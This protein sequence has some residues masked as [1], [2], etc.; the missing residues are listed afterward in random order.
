MVKRL[1]VILL[2]LTCVL[3]LTTCDLVVALASLS[4]FPGYL[5]QAVASV[6]MQK[7]VEEFLGEDPENWGSEVYALRDA[8]GAE[9]IFLILH[10][11]SGG[12]WVYAFDTSLALISKAYLDYNNNVHLVGPGP[13]SSESFVVGNIAFDPATLLVD[14]QVETGAGE[15]ALYN[16]S[17]AM[18]MWSYFDGGT[19]ECFLDVRYNTGWPLYSGMNASTLI[20]TGEDFELRG[21]THDTESNLV[22]LFFYNRERNYVQVSE[23]LSSSDFPSLTSPILSSY[24]NSRPIDRVEDRFFCYTRKGLIASARQRGFFVRFNLAGDELQRLYIGIEGDRE[25]DFD[26]LGEYYYV[27]NRSNYRLYKAATG[28]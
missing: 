24:S 18:D 4:P 12:Q 8:G 15:Y 3:G 26:V 13:L 23:I 25:M 27:F 7:E 16:G 19:G 1:L 10:K 20:T 17:Q 21:L 6:D 22:F 11:Y 5:A 2:I 14:G 28:F 9:G